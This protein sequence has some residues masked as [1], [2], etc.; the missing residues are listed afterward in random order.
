MDLSRKRRRRLCRGITLQLGLHFPL[1][2]IRVP[3]HQADCRLQSAPENV[4]R[5]W[6]FHRETLFLAAEISGRSCRDFSTRTMVGDFKCL[7]QFF[8]ALHMSYTGPR[9]RWPDNATSASIIHAGPGNTSRGWDPRGSGPLRHLAKPERSHQC[10]VRQQRVWWVDKG[11]PPRAR[12]FVQAAISAIR[13]ISRGFPLG[14]FLAARQKG[15]ATPPKTNPHGKT[16]CKPACAFRDGFRAVTSNHAKPSPHRR[17]QE[18]CFISFGPHYALEIVG[19]TG[20]AVDPDLN[21]AA[22]RQQ[23][24][25][26]RPRECPAAQGQTTRNAVSQRQGKRISAGTCQGKLRDS[27]IRTSH[28]DGRAGRKGEMGH[29]T[30]L[31]RGQ[32]SQGGLASER[33]K[34]AEGGSWG[35]GAHF[36]RDH[37]ARQQQTVR[38]SPWGQKGFPAGPEARL[39]PARHAKHGRPAGGGDVLWA[40]AW[41]LNLLNVK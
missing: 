32:P 10:G 5:D 23:R 30:L 11:I 34:P 1:A 41:G 15:R 14:S 8:V 19:G 17:F 18:M 37:I 28:L 20:H 31:L 24:P 6:S 21:R 39:P 29:W 16:E 38:T 26:T 2:N 22:P 27:R 40:D 12:A 4:I 9:D 25:P 3:R 35:A 36:L 33:K 13:A 7:V